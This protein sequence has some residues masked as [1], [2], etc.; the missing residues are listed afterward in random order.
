MGTWTKSVSL[1]NSINSSSVAYQGYY[2]TGTAGN[3]CSQSITGYFSISGLTALKG[4]TI[5]SMSLSISL[6]GGASGSRTMGFSSPLSISE[7]WNKGTK[8][9][10][11]TP[12]NYSSFYNAVISAINGSG[13][14]SWTSYK[15]D[16]TFYAQANDDTTKAY[17]RNYTR[18]SSASISIVYEDGPATYSIVYNKGANSWNNWPANQT[19]THGVNLTLSS[20]TPTCANTPTTTKTVTLNYN[21]NGQSNTTGTVKVWDGNWCRFYSWQETSTSVRYF[22]GDT[23][24]TDADASMVLT[25]YFNEDNTQ[26]FTLP[27]PTWS[28]HSFTGWNTN[29]NGTGT[30]YSGGTTYTST[31]YSTLYAQWSTSS[32]AISYY[33]NAQGGG[34]VSGLPSTHYKTYG[35]TAYISSTRPTHSTVTNNTYTVTFKM[36]DGTSSNYTTSSASK[37]T[38]YSFTK[39]NTNSSGTGT[40]Y[41]PG[42]SYTTNAALNLYAVWSSSTNNASVSNPGTPSRSGYSF[43]GWGTSSTS[44]S[45]VS[46]PQTITANTT[47]Y[48][49]WQANAP[50]TYTYTITFSGNGYTGGSLPSSIS[51]SGTDTSVVMGDIG[52]SVPTKSGYVFRGWSASS[53]YSNKRIVYSSSNG[54]GADKNGVSAVQTASTWTYATYC[55]NTGGSTSSRTL[56]LYAQWESAPSTYT[57]S[58]NANGGTGAPSSQTK[59][60]GQTL[61][62]SSTVPTRASESTGNVYTV[63]FDYGVGS[64]TTSYLNVNE[65]YVYS[66]ECWNTAANGNGTDYDPG[67]SFTTN[68]NTTLYAQWNQ[69]TTIPPTTLPTPNTM[70]DYNFLGWFTAASGGTK[71]GNAGESY[72]PSV[73]DVTLYAQW[74]STLTGT[75]VSYVAR[76]ISPVTGLSVVSKVSNLPSDEIKQ[77]NVTYAI[78]SVIPVRESETTSKYSVNCDYNDGSGTINTYTS[79]CTYSFSFGGWNTDSSDPNTGQIYNAGDSYTTNANLILYT[80]WNTNTSWADNIINLPAP[81][82]DGYQLKGW[83]TAPVGGTK[84]G[85]A[86]SSYEITSDLTLYAQ[87]EENYIPPTPIDGDIITSVIYYTSTLYPQKCSVRHYNNNT[88]NAVKRIDYRDNNNWVRVG[89]RMKVEE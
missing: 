21:G 50:T 88:W 62:L 40:N 74:V 2:G 22:P 83:Y 26:G 52:S 46:F 72:R 85:N 20:N 73:N 30:N 82:R 16:T 28:G 3:S 63:N 1:S 80:R 47:Y 39:W 64:G 49:I 19:K 54:G 8:T 17:T 87:W 68:A 43:V 23:Y 6:D 9:I 56:N 33:G 25:G 75:V 13:S 58:Y 31:S 41:S 77:P 55:S 51:K 27:S 89:E 14:V 67:D 4:K 57:I 84:I 35:T 69:Y 5:S 71:V 65:S 70:A 60:E 76:A 48:A 79:K 42:G 15:G 29:S 61:T 11:P 34:S 36:N 86:N 53:S 24:S 12:S 32:Y 66:F 59:T 18:F 44:S 37:T 7:S 45:G 78:S 81:T 38:S 10:N